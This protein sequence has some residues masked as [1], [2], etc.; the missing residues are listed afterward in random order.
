MSH[1]TTGLLLALMLL[2]PA[3]QG[4]AIRPRLGAGDQFRLAVTHTRENIGKPQADYSVTTP[5][6]VRVVSVG[7]DGLLLDWQPRESTL[8]GPGVKADPG[9]AIIGKV[10]GNTSYRLALSRDGE[11]QR[12]ANEA[13]VLP[14]LQQVVDALLAEMLKPMPADEAKRVEAFMRQ[15]LSPTVLVGTATREAQ[16]YLSMFGVTLAAGER[17]EAPIK[18][19]NPLGGDPIPA[20]LRIRM[21]SVTPDTATLSST[22]VYDPE[23]MGKLMQRLIASATA[24]PAADELARLQMTLSDEG[25]YVFDRKVTLF[26]E[27]SVVRRVAV[28]QAGRS[29][30]WVIRLVEGPTR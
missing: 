28:G 15:I 30:R 26:R 1:S 6:D 24:K 2:V 18:Q 11:F 29:D 10:I 20:T 21:E 22:V 17:I 25:T 7:A 23:A 9:L 13:V 12:L 3:P 5:V 14:K 19:P 4:V 27:V 16:T 8:S